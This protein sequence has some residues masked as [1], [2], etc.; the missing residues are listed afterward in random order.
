M[1]ETLDI[2]CPSLNASPM[3]ILHRIG[4]LSAAA[5]LALP[6]APVM[7]AK[8][9]APA[10]PV[11]TCKVKAADGLSYTVIKAGKGAMPTDNDRVI[12]NYRG[13]LK[14]DSSEFDTG[15]DAK[16]KVTGVVPGFSQGLKLMQAGG[17]YRLCIPAALGYGAEGTGPIP[18]NADLV[19][20]VDLLSFAAIPPKPSIAAEARAC[21]LTSPSG[22][23]YAVAR[24][25]AG[26]KPTDADMALVDIVTFDP[27]T[28]EIFAREDWEKI[29]MPRAAPQFAEGL[30]LMQPGASYRFCFPATEG[31]DGQQVPALNVVVDLIDVRTLPVVED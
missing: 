16:F 6:S 25:G 30:K 14:N 18:A 1:I 27:R 20:E 5:A 19:F 22:L 24:Q 9:K 13:V 7:A 29:P 15:K 10:K 11:L 3:I 23:S 4:A 31:Q 8:P 12:V 26:R 2:S 21:D 17:K 28:G